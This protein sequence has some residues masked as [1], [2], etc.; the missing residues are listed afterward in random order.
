MDLAIFSSE[1]I[2]IHPTLTSR[3]K[4]SVI[5][6]LCSR[7]IEKG[8]ITETYFQQVIDREKKHPTGLPTLPVASA[9]PHADPI[10]VKATG[11]SLAVL[12]QS[13]SFF[14]MDNPRQSLP[15]SLVFLMS[16]I[17]G[18]QITV[19]QWISSVLGNQEMVNQ[20]AE[21]KQSAEVYQIIKPYLKSI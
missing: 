15:V 17:K 11:I 7:M 3:S 2:F 5:R 8:Y 14:A 9:V 19:L 16:F 1:L 12:K 6:F 20:I 18:D 10:G 4:K 13:V 21:C